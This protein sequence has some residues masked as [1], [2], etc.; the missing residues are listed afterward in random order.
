MP[1]HP[2]TAPTGCSSGF[3]LIELA[4]VVTIIGTLAALAI[5]AF[6]SSKNSA[7]LSTLQND[8]RV[9]KQDFENFELENKSFPPSQPVAGRSPEGMEGIL[10]AAWK[11]P[12]PIGGTYRWVYTDESD[13]ADRSAYIELANTTAHPIRLSLDRL[14]ELDRAI[15]N[16]DASNGMLQLNGLNIRFY[17]RL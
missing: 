11:L 2:Q 16:G 4:I 5:P 3:S 8:L 17:L 6:R 1:P 9:F 14:Q 12:S 10:H 7:Q 15:D 13:P